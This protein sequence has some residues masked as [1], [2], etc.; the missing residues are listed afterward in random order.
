MWV[1]APKGREREGGGG[2]G[3]EK[4]GRG[5]GEG[6]E[7]GRK[8]GGKGTEVAGCRWTY[9]YKLSHIGIHIWIHCIS[10]SYRINSEVCVPCV[11]VGVSCCQLVMLVRVCV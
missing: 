8:R 10:G 3:R 6:E 7:K 1:G 11:V 4:G 2:R 5:E 9:H